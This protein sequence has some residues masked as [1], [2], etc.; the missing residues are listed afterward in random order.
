MRCWNC[1]SKLAKEAKVCPRCEAPVEE[2]PTEEEIEFVGQAFAMLDDESRDALRAAADE[3]KTAEEFANRVLIGDCPKCGSSKVGNCDADP[4]IEDIS[5]GRCYDCG[6]LW[7][8]FCDRLLAKGETS[9]DCD[10]DLGEES[11]S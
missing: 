2:A 10:P 8:T 7:C 11:D 1:N 9:C 5:I 6:Q 4:E 3:S